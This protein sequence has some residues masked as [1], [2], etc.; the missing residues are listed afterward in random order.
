[1]PLPLERKTEVDIKLARLRKKM[2]ELRIDAVRLTSVASTA[3][4][5]AGARTYVDESTEL[6]A[7]SVLITEDHA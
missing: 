5:T 3:W 6:A 4:I 2:S 1:M 7:S